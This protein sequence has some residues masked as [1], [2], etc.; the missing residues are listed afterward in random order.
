[1]ETIQLALKSG[2]NYIETGPWYGPSEEIIGEA[3][4][5]VP[6]KAFYISTKAGRYY[7]P[8]WEGR[9][10]FSASKVLSSVETSLQRLGL[11]YVDII[12][13]SAYFYLR[14]TLL[15]LWR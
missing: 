3:L 12:Q 11:S 7:T 8:D 2:V 4:K 6:R 13:V 15:T 9:F 1:M 5:D 14:E 10:D